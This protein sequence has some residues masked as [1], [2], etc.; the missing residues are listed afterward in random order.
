[1]AVRSKSGRRLRIEWPAVARHAVAIA[2]T[3]GLAAIVIKVDA[4]DALSAHKAAL[5][6]IAPDS[7]DRAFEAA[8]AEIATGAKSVPAASLARVK[9]AAS[10]APLSA[11]PYF[12]TGVDA[13]YR[14]QAA[15]GQAL[16]TEA[17]RRNPRHRL[18]RLFLLQE[19]LRAMRVLEATR[20]LKVLT[21][22]VPQV[23]TLIVPELAK[24]AVDP[25]T[26]SAVAGALRGDP[27]LN[28]VLQ[29]LA[30]S[31]AEPGV[32]LELA[33]GAPPPRGQDDPDW[34]NALVAQFVERKRYGEAFRLWA[35]FNKAPAMPAG[36]L[37]FNPRFER[38]PEPAPFNWLLSANS[39]GAAETQRAGGLTVE[40][41]GRESGD[42]TSQLLLLAPGRYR[43]QFKVEGNADGQGSL[44]LWSVSCA[45]GGARLAEAP[46]KGVT[47][48][49][50]TRAFDFTVP[51]QDCGAQML[52]LEGRAGE[53]PA[54][55]AVTIPA[56][57][58]RRLESTH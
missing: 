25:R 2:A 43:M 32:V 55:Q 6:A 16:L 37:V 17:R 26:R 4:P 27:L 51:A 40:Y 8:G 29:Q 28:H 15:K 5:A 41:F 47:Y 57:A 49:T 20:E 31:G 10:D 30:Q 19:D 3:L 54:T 22:L 58:L 24:L 12:V 23:T 56:L 36:Q 46:L 9:D 52:R 39:V 45:G 50:E 14:G 34:R 48:T 21:R 44:L 35:E 38:R 11:E 1:M 42:L 13:L 33:R 7:P 53:F 18:A